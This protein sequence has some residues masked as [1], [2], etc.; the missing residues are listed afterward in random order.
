MTRVRT[1]NVFGTI[2]DNPLTSGATTVN[3]AGLANLAA[4]ASPDYAV[5]TLDPN[6]V[7]GA[8]EIIYVTAHT[9]SA[10]SVTVLR[11]QE[12]TAAR[13]HDAGTF[14]V[15]AATARDFAL[16]ELGYAQVT[17]SQTGISTETDLTS[18]AATVTVAALRR[19]KITGHGLLQAATSAGAVVGRIKES[20]T[21][22][23]RFGGGM[24]D[25]NNGT[26]LS[27]G[28]VVITP[29][30]GSHTYKLTL[31]KESGGNTATLLAD[32]TF[33]AFILVEDIGPS[34][35]VQPS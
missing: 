26:L 11:A 2:T 23:G 3:S 16:G 34:R 1:D 9:G 14:W 35:T 15:H 33:P 24:I 7:D 20:T 10:T 6:G 13:E 29:T 32:A 5:I 12:G 27:D 18:L 21:T 25:A 30:A 8:P 17:T 19:I 28:S 4:V 22:L 31:E